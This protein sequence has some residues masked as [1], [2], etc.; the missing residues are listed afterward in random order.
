MLRTLA[1]I[2]FSICL[3]AIGGAKYIEYQYMLG[4]CPLCILQRIIFYVLGFLFLIGAIFKFKRGTFL[5][6]VYGTSISL[7]ALIGAMLAERQLW[8][9]Y[10]APPQ[11]ISCS[12]SLERLLAIH[13]WFDAL[14]IAIAGSSECA[15]I[16]FT[17]LGLS[18][19]GWGFG[20]FLL[21]FALG[22]YATSRPHTLPS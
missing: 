11:A 9:Q 6:Y 1:W 13:P 3:A 10:F 19:A 17:I 18:L 4:G 14:R 12:A 21:L 7:I 15:T 16:D 8:L 5:T 2:G 22:L 20:L